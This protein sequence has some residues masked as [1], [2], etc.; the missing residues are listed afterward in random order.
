MTEIQKLDITANSFEA[1][2]NK[3]LIH[4]SLT[5]KRFEVFERLQI[6]VSFGV[7]FDS[8]KNSIAKIYDCLQTFKGADASVIARNALEGI[9]RIDNK[10]KHPIMLLC[11]LFICRENENQIGRAHV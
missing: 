6:E 1:N 5:V 8:L 4:S 10:R 7:D 9:A 11:S 2:G 3:Y